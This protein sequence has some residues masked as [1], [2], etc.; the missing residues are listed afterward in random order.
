M[1]FCLAK[2]ADSK[3]YIER[4]TEFKGSDLPDLCDSFER[5]IADGGTGFSMGF[6]WIKA[7]NREKL[8]SYYKGLM[9]VPERSFY[10]GRLDGIIAS[11]IQLVK[12]S[13][14]NQFQNFAGIVREHFVAPWARGHGLAKMLISAVEDEARDAGLKIL[15]LEVR[16]TQEAAIA[17]YES[18]GFKKWGEL[19]KYEMV[20]GKFVSGYFYYKDLI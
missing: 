15:K 10:V 8:E 4:L 1:S 19:D 7:P 5:T 20:D 12:P 6:N 18:A 14:S 9:L 2:K 3:A 13:Q 11:T 17:M 16:A